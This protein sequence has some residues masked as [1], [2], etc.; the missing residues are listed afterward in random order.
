MRKGYPKTMRDYAI[1]V[2]SNNPEKSYKEVAAELGIN[3]ETLRQWWLKEHNGNSRTKNLRG[4]KSKYSEEF[5]KNA[6]EM[7]YMNP[8]KT[9]KTISEEL[10]I[11]KSML[12]SWWSKAVALGMYKNNRAN[13]GKNAIAKF[14]AERKAEALKA[15][16]IENMLDPT[17]EID[18]LKKELEKAN[19]TINALK[20]TIV[21]FCK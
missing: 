19:N 17:F 8:N 3:T 16:E 14:N 18:R 9:V 15:K 21:E 20:L 12:S 13:N 6:V 2:L 10:N 5:R 1:N 7:V 4:R 11:P